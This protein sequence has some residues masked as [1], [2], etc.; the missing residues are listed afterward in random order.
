VTRDGGPNNEFAK[1][2][3]S[4]CAQIQ[5]HN[6]LNGHSRHKQTVESGKQKYSD[7]KPIKLADQ[8]RHGRPKAA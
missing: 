2:M 5:Q 3:A 7:E 4:W 8:E 1:W 6:V